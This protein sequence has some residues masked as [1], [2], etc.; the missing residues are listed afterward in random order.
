MANRLN[1]DFTLYSSEERQAFINAYLDVDLTGVQD[2]YYVST[3]DSIKFP[4]PFPHNPTAAELETMADYVLYGKTAPSEGFDLKKD[5]SASIVD[6]G[7]VQIE[8]RNSPWN[9]KLPN[10]LDNLISTAN[11]TGNPVETQYGLAGNLRGK[12]D[13]YAITRIQKQ[14]FSRKET[15]ERLGILK[16]DKLLE[17]F[18][19]LWRRIDETEYTVTLYSINTN[20]RKTPIREELE[21]RLSDEQKRY[22]AKHAARLNMY[23]WSKLRKYLVELRQ[24]QYVL[25]DGYAPTVGRPR[26]SYYVA[27]SDYIRMFQYVLPA[28]LFNK[29]NVFSKYVFMY[30]LGDAHFTSEYL[31]ILI[32][33]LSELDKQH[34]DTARAFD[35][36]NPDHIALLVYAK[37][38]IDVNIDDYV[39][40]EHREYLRSLLDTLEYY[41]TMSKL[42]PL[43][44]DIVMLKANGTTNEN[45]AKYINMKYAKTYSPNYIS[46]IFRAKCCGGIAEAAQHHWEILDKLVAGKSEFKRCSTCKLLLLRNVDNYVRKARAK[47][48]LASRC[49]NCDKDI[50]ERK[51]R[52]AEEKITQQTVQFPPPQA[53]AGVSK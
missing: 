18:E 51:K 42:E 41:I 28:G 26:Q 32:S 4:F 45:I 53:A 49:K 27:H 2:N 13:R 8:V 35:F 48:G 24:Q 39:D 10:S 52:A 6:A 22:C 15:R 44:F 34:K 25:R 3:Y 29:Q 40:I 31:P 9:K 23:T 43:H 14:V 1:L 47:D 37:N 38:D 50:R 19:Y 7:Y 20:R 12:K 33:Y 5:G 16:D 21:K 30:E 36:R 11:E 46:T 17:E